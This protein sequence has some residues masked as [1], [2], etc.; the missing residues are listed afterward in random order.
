VE[1]DGRVGGYGVQL[2]LLLLILL[3]AIFTGSEMALLSLPV[4]GELAPLSTVPATVRFQPTVRA[5]HAFTRIGGV[6]PIRCRNR[7]P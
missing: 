3:N 4:L 6:G 7:T 1:G 5:G 2:A